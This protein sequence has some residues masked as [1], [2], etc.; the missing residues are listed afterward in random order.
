M[1]IPMKMKNPMEMMENPVMK[2]PMKIPM[3]KIM[4]ISN[5]KIC[6]KHF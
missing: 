1:K 6:T 5:P 2:I 3:M 4:M